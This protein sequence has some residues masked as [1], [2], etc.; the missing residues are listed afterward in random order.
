MSVV[1]K[2]NAK[3]KEVNIMTHRFI[4]IELT[5]GI[6]RIYNKEKCTQPTT[7]KDGRSEFNLVGLSDVGVVETGKGLLTAKCV[8]GAHSSNDFFSHA[9]SISYVLKRKSVMLI[10]EY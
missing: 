2:E 3:I 10:L 9:S 1:P 7:M 6:G 5:Q 4:A 8:S